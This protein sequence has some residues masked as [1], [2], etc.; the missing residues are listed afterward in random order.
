MKKIIAVVLSLFPLV[1]IASCGSAVPLVDETAATESTGETVIPCPE[2]CGNEI[3]NGYDIIVRPLETT[4]YDVDHVFRSLAVDP[5]DHNI[6][7]IGTERNGAFRSTDGGLTWEWLRRGLKHNLSGYPEFYDIAVS[8]EGSSRA[9]Y[10]ATTNGPSP[11]SGRYASGAGIYKLSE[12]GDTW[13][14]TNCGLPHAGLISVTVSPDNPDMLLAGLS[15]E[16]PTMT[17]LSGMVFPGGIYKSDDGG[18][19]WYETKVPAGVE[20]NA[21]RQIYARGET[22]ITYYTC[23]YNFAYPEYNMGLIESTDGGE[24]W[25]KFGPF[26]THNR[27]YFFDVSQDGSVFYVYE[28]TDEMKKIHKSVDGGETWKEFTG[29]FMGILKTSPAD[30]SLVLFD[31]ID[32]SDN[33]MPKLGMSSDGMESYSFVLD[34][35]QPVNDIEFAPSNPDVVYIATTGYDIYKSTDAGKSWTFLINLRKDIINK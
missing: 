5:L 17:Q 23:G 33:S 22:D 16:E 18:L 6:V 27:V 24:T 34:T 2:P 26:G 3:G 13:V 29:P 20:K 12:G 4:S 30:S 32:F 19:N 8:P 35:G 14:S 10:A 21:F 11:L 25:E 1:L 15:A 9:V 7:I 31:S 28:Y